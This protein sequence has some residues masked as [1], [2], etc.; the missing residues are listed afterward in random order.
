MSAASHNLH[1]E[2]EAAKT[3]KAQLHDLIGGDEQVMADVVEGETNLNEA[4]DEVVS[5]LV[6]DY[7]ALRGLDSM[8]ED[9][10]K[11]RER[12]KQRIDNIRTMIA[13]ALDQAGK[14]K[15][16]HPAVTLS[17]RA[18]AP[19]V[20]VVDE[21]QIP[22]KFW[23]PADPKLDKKAVLEHLKNSELIPGTTLN[24]GSTTLAVSWR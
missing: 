4:I 19:S 10:S 12:I 6:Q 3:L 20:V 18:V 15:V 23:K 21:A 2:I 5:H 17:I 9:L 11:R 22:S 16:E 13:V 14:K 24:N 8:M 7:A 1:R